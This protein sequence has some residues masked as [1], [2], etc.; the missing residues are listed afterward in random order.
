[1]IDTTTNTGVQIILERMKSHPEEFVDE[2]VSLLRG[3]PVLAK[4]KWRD[5]SAAVLARYNRMGQGKGALEWL[6]DD[7]VRLIYEGLMEL[8]RS[9]FTGD[10]MQAIAGENINKYAREEE[11]FY[12][13][14]PVSNIGMIS[15]SA[16]KFHTGGS[17]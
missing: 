1:M 16:T 13:S 3:E 15:A 2:K 14:I 6:T 10:V 9:K 4:T 12:S 5:T 17:I 8:L 7:E 11:R